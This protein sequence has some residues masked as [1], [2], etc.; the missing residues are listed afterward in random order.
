MATSGSK[1]WTL[2]R[3]ALI[4]RAMRLINVIDFNETPTADQVS[5][6]SDVLNGMVKQ[7]M[8]DGV[9]LV[10]RTEGTLFLT[11]GTNKYNLASTRFA[12]TS[13]AAITTTSAAASS[14]ASSITVTSATGIAAS[15]IIGIELDD[16]T[17]DW[18]TVSGSPSGTT[19]TLGGTLGGAAASGNS[20]F[21]YTTAIAY[22]PLD[23]LS[24]RREKSSIETPMDLVSHEEYHNL[25]N[26]TT[27]A[28]PTVCYFDRQLSTGDLYVW[29]TPDSVKTYLRVTFSRPFD[30][31]DA[32]ANTADLP[33][34]WLEA[35]AYNLA[36][37]IGPEYGVPLPRLQMLKAEAAEYLNQL[38]GWDRD[39]G[40][41]HFQPAFR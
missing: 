16:G 27:Q 35:L 19:V 25:P 31:F 15:D 21:V 34:E 24:V 11:K 36:V 14:G 41:I 33:V 26:K 2:N 13:D 37:R 9:H 22:Q 40:S 23:V 17:I 12:L 1:D 8:A 28:T 3:D 4:Q 39:F 18:D 20:V 38:R 6:A 29:P 32:Q 7:W 10:R 5:D 30:D